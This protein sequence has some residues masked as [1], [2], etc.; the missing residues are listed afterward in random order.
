MPGNRCTSPWENWV[1]PQAMGVVCLHRI[2]LGREMA[3]VS[4]CVA[5]SGS[6]VCFERA[7]RATCASDS[8]GRHA[9]NVWRHARHGGR[10]LTARLTFARPEYGLQIPVRTSFLNDPTSI[11]VRTWFSK[12]TQPQ[13][14]FG[15]GSQKRPNLNPRSDFVLRIDAT[16]IPD[17]T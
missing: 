9:R 2:F 12:T 1:R 16:S 14:P 11:P 4:V 8:H 3:D 10:R 7:A 5:L 6:T 13:S 15:L 17:T